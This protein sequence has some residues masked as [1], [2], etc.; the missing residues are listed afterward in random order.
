MPVRGYYSGRLRRRY[1]AE[2]VSTRLWER[3]FA[4]GDMGIAPPTPPARTNLLSQIS[5]TVGNFGT[6][7]FTTSSFTPPNNSLLVVGEVYVENNATT[8]DPTSA[9]TISGGGWTY[10]GQVSAVT[11]P[12]SF[13]TLTKIWTAPVTTGASHT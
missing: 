3:R 2:I 8:T 4:L 10:T 7:N 9:L 5:G 6:G 11:Q 1:T 13:P 12:T